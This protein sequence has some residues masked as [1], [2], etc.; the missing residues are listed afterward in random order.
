MTERAWRRSGHRRK[1]GQ[2]LVPMVSIAWLALVLSILLGG[3]VLWTLGCALVTVLVTG[4]WLAQAALRVIT[5][6]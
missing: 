2:L 5:G 1:P 6:R 4:I 3:P